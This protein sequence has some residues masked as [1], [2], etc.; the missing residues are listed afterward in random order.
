MEELLPGRKNVLG[1]MCI[2]MTLYLLRV[3]DCS[4]YSLFSLYAIDMESQFDDFMLNK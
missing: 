2:D 3:N 1:K 4:Y